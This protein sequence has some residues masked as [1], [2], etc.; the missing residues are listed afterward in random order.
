[1]KTTIAIPCVVEHLDNI[2]I[3]LHHVV[4]GTVLPDEVVIA[5]FP[6]TKKEQHEKIVNIQNKYQN[7]FQLNIL[8]STDQ[9]PREYARN[10]LIPFL[11]G[12]LILWHD[13][14]DT[15]HPQRIEIV[16]RFF[17]EYDIVHLCHAYRMNNEKEI[18]HI[19]FDSIQYISSQ[20]IF[21][22][23]DYINK[24]QN[25]DILDRTIWETFAF[26]GGFDMPIHAGVCC[27]K[28]EV[29][30][31]IKFT[32]EYP[33]EDSKF[34]FDILMQHKKTILIDAKIY[35]YNIIE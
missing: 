13:A 28:K 15:Q 35:N 24:L 9:K 5:V 31:K 22:H 7:Y 33:G 18:G 21:Q 12:D 16:K 27:V 25:Y 6:V 14:D 1:M 20:Q 4:G 8:E 19:D 23:K 26:G 11:S 17:E 3:L 2:D 29:L 10:F 30:E 34:C 32:R